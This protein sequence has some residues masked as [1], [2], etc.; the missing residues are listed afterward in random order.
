MKRWVNRKHGFNV[1]D[2]RIDAFLSDIFDVCRKHHL[3]ISHEDGHGAFEID[4]FI[5]SN[6]KWLENANDNTKESPDGR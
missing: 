4:D 3:S 5:E 1:S 6:L 2:K